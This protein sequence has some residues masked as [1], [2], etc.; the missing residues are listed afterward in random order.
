MAAKKRRVIFGEN[1]RAIAI[2]AAKAAATDREIAKLIGITEQTF[3]RW[4]KKYPDFAEELNQARLPS[5]QSEELK[6]IEQRKVW[7]NDWLDTYLRTQGEV[8]E[9]SICSVQSDGSELT[10]KRTKGK[11]P[12]LRLIERVLGVNSQAEQFVL[13]IELADP[14]DDDDEEEE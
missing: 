11:A 12:D 2:N 1:A 8:L 7:A 9:T 6:R 3:Y 13:K 5:S 14:I 10:E 4:L